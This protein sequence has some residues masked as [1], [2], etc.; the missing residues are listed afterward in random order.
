MF[1]FIRHAA[2]AAAVGGV[3]FSVTVAVAA[4]SAVFGRTASRRRDAQA[5]L[6]ILLRRRG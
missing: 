3:L 6:K 5:V 2:L 1:E 4:L